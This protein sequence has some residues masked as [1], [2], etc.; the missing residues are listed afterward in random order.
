MELQYFGANCVR[1]TTK[2]ASLVVDDNLSKIG[3][4][5]ITKPTDICLKTAP[6]V[7]VAEGRFLADMPGEYEISGVSIKGIAARAHMDESD[8]KTAV[9]YVVK[10]DETRVVILGHVFPELSEEQLEQIGIVD[11]A[12]IPIGN[13]GYTLDGAGALSLIKKIEPK[14]IVPTHYGD[15]AI[16]YEV[17]Q[18]E[19][20]EA[21]KS[22]AMEPLETVTKYKV[23]SAELGDTTKLVVLERQ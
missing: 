23:N 2:K 20:A 6:Y 9:I 12:I 18:Q 21:L 11:V 7:D 1:L 3:L 5:S 15:K 4:K 8:K 22:L 16:N 14:I 17:P 10:A 19:L 13:S